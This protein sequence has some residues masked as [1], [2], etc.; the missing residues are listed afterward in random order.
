MQQLKPIPIE[1]VQQG[2]TKLQIKWNDKHI[3]DYTAQHLRL[4][5]RCAICVDEATGAKRLKA[6]DVADDIRILDVGSV[7]RYAIRILW[8]DGHDTGIYTFEHL[9]SLCQ[10]SQCQSK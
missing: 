1:I 9:R 4:N 6:A 2:E 8:S 5:C 10:C 3:S 7:G